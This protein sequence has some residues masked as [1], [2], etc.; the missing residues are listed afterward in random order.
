MTEEKAIEVIARNRKAAFQ[1][2]I[3]DKYEA[4]IALMGTEVKSLRD[5]QVSISE[6]FARIA[7]GE[8]LLYNTQINPYEHGNR[9]NHDP[10][11]VRKLLLH[12]EEIGRIAGKVQQRGFTLVP[13]S[14]YFK[15]G[16][17]KIELAV[18]RGKSFADKRDTLR[19]K[20]AQRAIKQEISK[21]KMTPRGG[22]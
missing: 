6:S 2:H 3:L 12:K 15:N 13:L 11:R 7:N 8:V 16:I 20:D 17:A 21:R 22:R 1:Y 14:V 19:A 9:F 4:G 5:R 18:A 10:K